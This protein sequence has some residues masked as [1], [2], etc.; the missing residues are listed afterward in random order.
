MDQQP[1]YRIRPVTP[2]DAFQVWG[3][4]RLAG[5]AEEEAALP[6]W[7]TGLIAGSAV[8][9]GAEGGNGLIGM[10][11][12]ISDGVSDAYI[13][14]VVV[15]PDWRR[16]GIGVQLVRHVREELSRRGVDWIGL[17]ATPGNTDFYRALGFETAEGFT[18]M[19]FRG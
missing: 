15:H 14:D 7:V 1:Q 4:L 12:A 6:Q 10:A 5:W 2:E 13:Q 11:R 19:I 17:V 9:Y 16:R 18:P 3:L 8:F